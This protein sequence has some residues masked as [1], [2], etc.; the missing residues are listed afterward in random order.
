M[1]C[2]S[3]LSSDERRFGQNSSSGPD[4]SGAAS[5]AVASVPMRLGDE[6]SSP[7]QI[8]RPAKSQNLSAGLV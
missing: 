6:P 3:K 4:S 7:P 8:E 2:A 5:T 1:S